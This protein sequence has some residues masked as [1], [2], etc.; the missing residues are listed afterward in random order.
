MKFKIKK[1]SVLYGAAIEYKLKGFYPEGFTVD[2][3][4]SARRKAKSTV[5]HIVKFSFIQISIVQ[6]LNNQKGHWLT[7]STIGCPHP[8]VSVYNSLPLCQNMSQKPNCIT[9]PHSVAYHWAHLYGLSNPLGRLLMWAVRHRQ[10]YG[11]SPWRCPWTNWT[12]TFQHVPQW[13]YSD[14][15]LVF[16][17]RFKVHDV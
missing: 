17:F 14:S 12:D 9:P 5:E 3:K 6:I 10:C 1:N 13:W 7:V 16:S 2:Q 4:H 15:L 8:T 11:S